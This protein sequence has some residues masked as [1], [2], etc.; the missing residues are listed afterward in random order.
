MAETMPG[1]TWALNEH[2]MRRALA[3][4]VHAR[5][6][7]QIAA[8]V[9]AS[10]LA[11]LHD[12]LS[13]GEEHAYLTELLSIHGAEA[14][15]ETTTYFSRDLGALRLRWERHAEFSTYTFLRFDGYDHP[16]NDPALALV[17]AEWLERLP[18]K[19]LT[20]THLALEKAP[21][22]ADDISAL[23]D[24]NP[25]IAAK[26]IGSAAEC[27]TDFRLHA[28]G[29]GR[30][31]VRDKD[32][33][34]GQSGRVMQRLLEIETYRM[35]ALLA[36]PPARQANAEM[37]RMDS[38]LAA[39]V[40]ELADPAIAQNDRE[41]LERLTALAAEAERLDAATSFRLGAARAYYAIVNQR[42]A[43]LRE[44]RIPGLQTIGEFMDRR[45]APAMKT[46]ESAAERQQLLARR[47]AR[48]GDLLR[49]RVDIALE[50]KN[51]DLLRSM[52]RRAQLQLRLQE[53]VEGLSVVAISY[54]LLGLV[55]YAAKGLK[56]AGL[57][58]DADIAALVA[59]PVIIG[60]VIL[61]VRRLRRALVNGHGED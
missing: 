16:F 22:S 46:C 10:H 51:R 49:T 37:F 20:A 58:V 4:E 43:E 32:L 38:G 59:L 35:M 26:I 6:Y 18:G 47:A 41:L 2:S 44:D 39:I 12:G 21:R 50:E 53:T 60:A 9:R 40:T 33:T 55:L 7:E 15:A 29:F 61:G 1:R 23:F 3:G 5:P 36:F 45:L 11:V 8:P 14:P 48:A 17:P 42:I 25:L 57:P 28:D 54:Y 13:A 34:K 27:W 56:G 31:W 19:V 52:N 30:I 24:G